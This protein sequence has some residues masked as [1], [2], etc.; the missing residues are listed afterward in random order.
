MK[1]PKW[2]F[3]W[4]TSCIFAGFLISSLLIPT[5]LDRIIVYGIT[6]LVFLALTIIFYRIE[7]N[8]GR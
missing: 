3:Y 6:Y 7:E 2:V 5:G 1:I 8:N 4:W